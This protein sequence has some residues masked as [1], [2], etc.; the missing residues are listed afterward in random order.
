MSV[1]L[2]MLKSG[3]F[4]AWNFEPWRLSHASSSSFDERMRRQRW[5]LWSGEQVAPWCAWRWPGMEEEFTIW[6]KNRPD[7]TELWKNRCVLKHLSKK[8]HIYRLRVE[9]L[10]S[11]EIWW[12]AYLLLRRL[13]CCCTLM[14]PSGSQNKSYR[15]CRQNYQKN[16]SF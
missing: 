11:A 12:I 15:Q 7:K 8:L 6:A 5:H 16:G 1:L 3:Y 13:C 10:D 2:C 9:A 4:R 14:S